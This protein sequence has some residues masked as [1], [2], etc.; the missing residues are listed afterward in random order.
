MTAPV[1]EIQN[2]RREMNRIFSGIGQE[3]SQNF[4]AVN[5]WVGENDAMVKA[6][7]PGAEIE[8]IDISVIVDSLTISGSREPVTLGEGESYHRQERDFG[9]FTRTLQLPFNVEVNKVDARYE[10][11]I[12]SI[13]LPRA[14]A[15]KP[16]KVAIKTQ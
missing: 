15:D 6:E 2:L 9:R 3:V 11:G 13:T 14:E 16:K 12:L 10:N 4:P 1:P 7:I 8:K 5:V